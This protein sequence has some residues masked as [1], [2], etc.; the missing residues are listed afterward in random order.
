MGYLSLIWVRNTGKH[1]TPESGTSGFKQGF[2]TAPSAGRSVS[3]HL[4]DPYQMFQVLLTA[5]VFQMSSCEIIS[6]TP[7]TQKQVHGLRLSQTEALISPFLKTKSQC[8]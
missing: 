5:A 3:A 2:P 6:W 8:Y 4:L 1:P 7:A